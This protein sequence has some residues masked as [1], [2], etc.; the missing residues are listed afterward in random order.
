MTTFTPLYDYVLI[1]PDEAET[2]TKSGLLYVPDVAQNTPAHGTVLAVGEGKLTGDTIVALKVKV[3]D[4]VMFGKYS[5][6][7]VEVD[8]EKLIA[9]KEMDILGIL[10]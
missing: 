7:E 9:T 4:R 2:K 8:G 3:G 1:R 5:G 6:Y 10:S